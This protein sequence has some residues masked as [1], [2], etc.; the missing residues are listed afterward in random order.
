[1]TRGWRIRPAEAGDLEGAFDISY[2]NAF[3][4]DPNP[5]PRV[6]PTYPAHVLATG[7]MLVAE[8]EGRLLGFAGLI[9]RGEVSFLTDLFVR[10]AEQSGAIGKSLLRQILPSGGIHCTMSS[11]DPRALALYI[12]AG[13]RPQWPQFEL[14]ASSPALETPP[15]SDVDTIEA[16]PDEPELVAWEAEIGG[17]QRPEDLAFWVRDQGAVPLWFRRR[18]VIIGYAYVRLGAG[19]L[20]DPDAATI[21]PLGVRRVEDAAACTLAAVRWARQRAKVLR[22]AVPGP[23]PSL[24]PLIEL[25]LRIV[26]LDTFVSSAEK[27]F[28]DPQRYI[29]S[30]GDLL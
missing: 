25:G 6:M 17:R 16:Q 26:D 22:L 7:R 4:D 9:T 2:E 21:G 1:M 27:P 30:G 19:T 20:R 10:P 28:F 5:P 13:M 8:Q 14:R 15:H 12:R 11:A 24:A 29:G 23:H 18:G 3:G